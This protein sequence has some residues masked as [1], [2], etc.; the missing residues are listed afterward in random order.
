MIKKIARKG[1]FDCRFTICFVG[2]VILRFFSV[3]EYRF[4]V[5]SRRR[6]KAFYLFRS[7]GVLLIPVYR[8]FT[9]FHK[10]FVCFYKMSVTEKTVIRRK[11]RRVRA[12]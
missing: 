4:A 5:F 8:R 11:R 6:E 9:L 3:T 2:F 10:V 12:F 7:I 1:D